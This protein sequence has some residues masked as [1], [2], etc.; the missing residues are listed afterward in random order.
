MNYQAYSS[1]TAA[2][3]G[4]VCTPP[5][6]PPPSPPQPNNNSSN[7]STTSSIHS[8]TP[9]EQYCYSA[10]ATAA[11]AAQN[12]IPPYYSPD[13][14][15]M[16]SL[17]PSPTPSFLQQHPS[18]Q[19]NT[20]FNNIV[21]SAAPSLVL[22]NSF[23]TH[24][25]PSRRVFESPLAG[26]RY[27]PVKEQELTSII[28]QCMESA[29][30]NPYRS[31]VPVERIQNIARAEFA[32]LYAMVVGTRHNS[33]RNFI[34]KH[35]DVFELFTIEDGKWKMRLK[36]HTDWREGDRREWEERT[37][38]ENHYLWCLQEYLRTQP[39]STCKVD[40]FMEAYH[41]LPANRRSP[42][43]C[44]QL[45]HPLCPRGD[46][47]RFIRHHNAYFYYNTSKYTV[48]LKQQPSFRGMSGLGSRCM[49]K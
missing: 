47:V 4:G 20:P 43:D 48:E 3:R 14:G 5:P 24:Q 18:Y 35:N 28:V 39:N 41:T 15:T 10:A 29:E 37:C 2:E 46:L 34:Q 13:G 31:S 45:L 42:R 22:Y 7:H 6:P 11:A 32:D 44:S 25:P 16:S 27:I 17:P 23:E 26:R 40:T 19:W 1:A 8:P 49:D 36:S 12:L 33:W 38:R 9:S 30:I 21:R